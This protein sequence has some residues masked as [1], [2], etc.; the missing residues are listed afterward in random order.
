MTRFGH[1]STMARHLRSRDVDGHP[2]DVYEINILTPVTVDKANTAASGTFM[3]LSGDE[4]ELPESKAPSK[5][6]DVV[7]QLRNV[8]RT[9]AALQKQLDHTT[10]ELRHIAHECNELKQEYNVLKQELHRT[11]QYCGEL[12]GYSADLERRITNVERHFMYT[13]IVNASHAIL[14]LLAPGG[15]PVAS[16]ART[17]AH[18]SAAAFV[19]RLP[20]SLVPH[21]AD[22]HRVHRQFK[23]LVDFT[24]GRGLCRN[25]ATHPRTWPEFYANHGTNIMDLMRTPHWREHPLANIA[26]FIVRV[27]LFAQGQHEQEAQ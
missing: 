17:M 8:T 16:A 21:H 7:L 13:T 11:A 27:A 1:R 18:L 9:V 2:R 5:R 14:G 3:S 12:Q 4:N 22:I 19:A 15:L 20:R 26:A 10:H 23:D 25:S 6:G 24:I